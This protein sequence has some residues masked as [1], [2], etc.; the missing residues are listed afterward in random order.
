ML[1]NWIKIA[2]II[3]ATLALTSIAYSYSLWFSQTQG[4]VQRIQT[5]TLFVILP[6]ILFQLLT[7]FTL[8]SLQ[9]HDLSREWMIHLM[10]GFIIVTI[11][12]FSFVYYLTSK[13]WLQKIWLSVHF[14]G[15]LSMIF[16]MAN[17]P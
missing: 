15:L 17:K 2:H 10:I 16:L 3:C 5:Q 13:R 1:Y 14:S 7:G 11:S 4:G 8:I 12:W 6:A 9:L